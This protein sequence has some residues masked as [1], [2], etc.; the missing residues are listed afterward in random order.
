MRTYTV[1]PG[2]TLESIARDLTGDPLNWVV[3]AHANSIP[4][5][6]P[7]E[8]GRVLMIPEPPEAAEPEPRRAA[9]PSAPAAGGE[10]A[11]F[12]LLVAAILFAA[13]RMMRR[14]RSR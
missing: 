3:I 9:A 14:R 12:W 7:L 1:K 11:A 10:G 8:P 4:E 2:D 13:S 5:G 6:T